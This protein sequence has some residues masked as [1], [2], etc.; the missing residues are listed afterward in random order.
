MLTLFSCVPFHFV[1][2][3]CFYNSYKFGKKV[4]Y[5]NRLSELKPVLYLDQIDIPQE[6]LRYD[7]SHVPESY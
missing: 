1:C 6:V 7:T 3:Y 2:V 5:I 4:V